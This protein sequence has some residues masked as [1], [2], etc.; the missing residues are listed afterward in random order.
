[1]NKCSRCGATLSPQIS[2]CGQCYSPVEPAY[3]PAL[4]RETA[5]WTNDIRIVPAAAQAD[6]V[7][8]I[9][10]SPPKS[11]LGAGPTTVGI[12]GKL[13]ISAVLIGFGVAAFLLAGEWVAIVGTPGNALRMFLTVVYSAL[14]VIVLRFVWRFERPTR[15]TE[16]GRRERVVYVGGEVVRVEHRPTPFAD[17]PAAEPSTPEQVP[18]PRP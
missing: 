9:P 2:W 17:R 10:E 3:E 5:A 7:V 15:L 13:L 4:L 6:R 12:L 1:M 18:V 16:T 14:T 11:L 8:V